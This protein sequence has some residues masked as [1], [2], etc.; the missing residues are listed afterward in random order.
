MFSGCS[1][2]PRRAADRQPD[3][4]RGNERPGGAAAWLG[5]RWRCPRN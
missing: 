2:H 4:A 5:L 1:V 3:A